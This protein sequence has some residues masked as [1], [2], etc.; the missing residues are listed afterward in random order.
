MSKYYLYFISSN[1]YDALCR[2]KYYGAVTYV[3]DTICQINCSTV[4]RKESCQVSCQV[5]G[6]SVMSSLCAGFSSKILILFIALVEIIA[7]LPCALLTNF[8][9]GHSDIPHIIHALD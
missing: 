6:G 2:N 3:F 1:R 4:V 8:N 5:R 7:L 9:Q